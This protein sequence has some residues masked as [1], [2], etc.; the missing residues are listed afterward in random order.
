[1]ALTIGTGFPWS[2][3]AI[4]VLENIF[5]PPG[6]KE[7]ERLSPMQ[8]ALLGA[9]E[10]GFT[11]VSMSLSLVAGIHPRAAYGRHRGPPVPGFAVTLSV[12]ILMSLVVSL[13][14][15]GHDV[16]AL[17]CVRARSGQGARAR[18][19]TLAEGG[20]D[21]IA[22][23]YEKSLALALRH[24]LIMLLL[25]FATIALNVYLYIIVPK[26]FFRYTGRRHDCRRHP[27]RSGDLRSSRCAI[28]LSEFVE[29][30]RQDPAVANVVAFTGGGQRNGGNMFVIL[31]PLRRAGY[32][33]RCRQRAPRQNVAHVPGASVFFCSSRT[34]QS[35]LPNHRCK[36][37]MISGGT[38]F[39]M[40]DKKTL[41]PGTW[42]RSDAGAR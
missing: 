8:A 7:G 37:M 3:D 40:G 38:A 1:M 17:G 27:G 33:C 25:F 23:G 42:A 16:L 12:A 2:D 4:V 29:I 11:V 18:W 31:K 30:V 6:E 24:S 10:V 9:R 15:V 34:S 21:A 19:K 13:N 35:S 41:A 22:R 36:A 14:A 28:K 5:A 39:L 20:F 32:Q 26:G